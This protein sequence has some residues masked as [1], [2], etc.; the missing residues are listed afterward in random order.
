MTVPLYLVRHVLKLQVVAGDKGRFPCGPATRA[1]IAR[2]G[3]EREA[4]LAAPLAVALHQVLLRPVMASAFGVP[5]KGQQRLCP[6]PAIG[7]AG[8]GTPFLLEHVAPPLAS[9]L[10]PAR[11]VHLHAPD[12]PTV[13][14]VSHVLVGTES[15]VEDKFLRLLE[16]GVHLLLHLIYRRFVQNRRRHVTLSPLC[17]IPAQASASCE[18]PREDRMG[19]SA[20]AQGPRKGF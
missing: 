9:G 13:A 15:G 5:G 14:Q 2:L 16:V 10:A 18:R 12:L 17:G 4:R 19:P 3:G 7:M 6:I 1:A 20:S 8:H 11:G